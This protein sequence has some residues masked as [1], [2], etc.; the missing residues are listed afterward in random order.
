MKNRTVLIVASTLVLTVSGMAQKTQIPQ[1]D[2]SGS[3]DLQRTLELLSSDAAKKYVAPVVTGFG[4][5]L[6]AGWF[7]RAP[8]AVTFGFDFELGVVAMG[9]LFADE[10]K[11]F[12]ATGIFQFDS[13]Q[14]AYLTENI[15]DPTYNNLLP[16]QREQV[17]QQILN[18]IRGKDFTVGMSGPTIIGSGTD[19]LKVEFRG[20]QFTYTDPFG[21]RHTLAVP[22]DSLVLPVTGLLGDKKILGKNL[23]PLAA[24]QLTIG[25]IFGTQFTFRYLPQYKISDEIGKTKYF[26]WGIQHN[27]A[28]W[29]PGEMP[30][31][32]SVSFFHQSIKAGSIFKA[33]ATAFG[34]N[35]S[36]Q[37]GW[38]IL[39]ITPYVGYM[40]EKSSMTFTYDFVL[41]TPTGQVPQRIVFDLVGENKSRLTLGLSIRLLI[42]NVNADYN[43]GKFK[44]Y[45]AG[46]M[47][48]I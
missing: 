23:V 2:S 11:R 46:V 16:A 10:N 17:R 48:I 31:D 41:D 34:V 12:S 1:S 18:Q 45:S 3:K 13:S 40:L 15:N 8:R 33:S 36:T 29:F 7:H 42:V 37:V 39:N 25:T 47:I 44:S 38:D 32:I 43:I 9:T 4:S 35:A 20:G 27:P 5:D 21:G 30:F 19:S 26:G 14:A 22:S 6:N 24:P 28:V